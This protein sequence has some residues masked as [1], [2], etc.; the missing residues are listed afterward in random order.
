VRVEFVFLPT[1]YANKMSTYGPS[2]ILGRIRQQH[3]GEINRILESD[4]EKTDTQC[5][6]AYMLLIRHTGPSTAKVI[7]CTHVQD[8][9]YLVQ[10]SFHLLKCQEPPHALMSRSR[11][12]RLHFGSGDILSTTNFSH[13]VKIPY[14][15]HGVRFP[16]LPLTLLVRLLFAEAI[17]SDVSISDPAVPN[18]PFSHKYLLFTKAFI[19]DTSM[20][21]FKR[22]KRKSLKCD[23]K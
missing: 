4:N 21:A 2:V 16:T 3:D 20:A 7:L 18:T 17:V 6:V 9:C 8:S 13:Y 10:K 1:Y 12:E 23:N 19:H 11:A 15:Y 5:N 14:E 22:L